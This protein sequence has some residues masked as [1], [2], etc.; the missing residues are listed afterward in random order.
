MNSATALPTP[1][2]APSRTKRKD[3]LSSLSL[4]AK[5]RPKTNL[6]Y[7]YLAQA[8]RAIREHKGCPP[9]W[10]RN[11]R[12]FLL[13]LMKEVPYISAWHWAI[14]AVKKFCKHAPF[15]YFR[16]VLR[17]PHKFRLG[18]AADPKWTERGIMAWL[19]RTKGAAAARRYA[20]DTGLVSPSTMVVQDWRTG[21]ER[22]VDV[23]NLTAAKIRKEKD[24][25]KRRALEVLWRLKTN[26]PLTGEFAAHTEG[27][28]VYLSTP[29]KATVVM[30]FD[31]PPHGTMSQASR[32]KAAIRLATWRSWKR[33][34]ESE[35]SIT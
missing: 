20:L 28:E 6:P 13:K 1:S 29:D 10:A 26:R 31:G 15:A 34:S 16:E 33:E 8:E 3:Y 17:N 32:R 23:S 27:Q 2:G 12:P 21:K 22:V 4:G 18:M 7:Y 19:R 11:I 5:P 35:T 9:G 25:E 24:P 30:T 14:Q